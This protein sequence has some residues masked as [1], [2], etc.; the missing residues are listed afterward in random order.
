MTTTITAVLAVLFILCVA[1]WIVGILENANETEVMSLRTYLRLCKN[2]R[3]FNVDPVMG[4]GYHRENDNTS[5]WVMPR[6]SWYPIFAL[7]IISS[8]LHKDVI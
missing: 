1:M 5:D 3:V 2:G 4:V 8:A 7:S 6:W